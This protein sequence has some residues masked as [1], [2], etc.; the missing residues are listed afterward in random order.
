MGDELA[1][2]LA[3][4]LNCAHKHG[5]L[6]DEQRQ[7]SLSL[8]FKKGDRLDAAMYMYRPVAVLRADFKIAALILTK[9]LDPHLSTICAT[10]Q[11]G[12]IK[13]RFI[14]ENVLRLCDGMKYVQH[15]NIDDAVLSTD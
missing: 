15:A 4:Q 11:T 9:C 2:V 7:G 13:H 8:L 12:F 3:M 6:T 5:C 10:D 1:P 14:H